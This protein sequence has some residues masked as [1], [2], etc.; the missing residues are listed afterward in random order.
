MPL[1]GRRQLPQWDSQQAERSRND[2]N[3]VLCISEHLARTISKD[4]TLRQGSSAVMSIH[5]SEI[6]DYA[7]ITKQSGPSRKRTDQSPS[8]H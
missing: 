4:R 3:P 1:P 7:D 5:T 2:G 8:V 6:G